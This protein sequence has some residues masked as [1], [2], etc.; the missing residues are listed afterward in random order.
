[1]K[2][3]VLH[4]VGIMNMGGLENLIMNIYRNI[5][6]EKI[7]FDFLVTREEKGIFDDEITS[8][9]G[10]IYN[11]PHMSK[12]GCIKYKK[13]VYDFFKNNPQYQIIHCHRDALNSLYLRQAKKNNVPVRIAHSHN[14][15]LVEDKTIKGILKLIIKKYFMISTNKNSTDYFACSDDAAKWLFGKNIKKSVKIIN[16]G[17]ESKKYKYKKNIATNIRKELGINEDT[18]LIGNV[19][20]FDLQKNH[21]FLIDVFNS[22]SK[23]TPNC[24]LCLVGEGTLMDN[25]KYKVKTLNIEDKVIFL[26]IRNNINEIMMGFDVFVFPSLF[27]GLGIVLIES[28]ASGLNCLVSDQVPKESDMDMNLINYIPID[29]ID[30]WVEKLKIINKQKMRLR[31][32]RNSD[33][34]KIMENGYDIA[35][36]VDYLENFYIDKYDTI[37]R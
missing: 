30:I 28:Q 24:K 35:T 25:I 31:E 15:R 36:T 19:A 21:D 26:G 37:Q 18:L 8:L 17:I 7:Q 10:R 11:I 22:F 5:D 23:E 14:I 3:R 13:I 27:E 33:I 20:R 12:V 29:K 2:I 16:N 6:R 32:E 1:M 4:I 9:G 34:S